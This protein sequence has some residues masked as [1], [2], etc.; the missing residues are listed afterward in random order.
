MGWVTLDWE[1]VVNIWDH[2]MNTPQRREKT[3]EEKYEET[4][5]R[6]VESILTMELRGEDTF[7]IFNNHLRNILNSRRQ[8]DNESTKSNRSG[9][10]SHSNHKDES[11]ELIHRD[12][13]FRPLM[14]FLDEKVKLWDLLY[15]HDFNQ[16][17]WLVGQSHGQRLREEFD[18]I[19]ERK[20]NNKKMYDIFKK[21][22][23]QSQTVPTSKFTY[24]P[25]ELQSV[26][27]REYA[28][29]GEFIEKFA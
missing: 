3:T 22:I 20:F 1:L 5:K 28:A 11:Y 14:T 12:S 18:L 16:L 19:L 25:S 26:S 15:Y 6:S 24:F 7:K 2:E 4:L 9:R 13:A 8:D 21:I 29:L 23:I 27:E 17:A 10:S